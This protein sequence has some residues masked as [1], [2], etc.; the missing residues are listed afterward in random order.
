MILMIFC[1]YP[2][3]GEK[4]WKIKNYP[5]YLNLEKIKTFYGDNFLGTEFPCLVFYVN[6]HDGAKRVPEWKDFIKTH[7]PKLPVYAIGS[8]HQ[9][10]EI[11][12]GLLKESLSSEPLVYFY[13]WDG[14]V[15]QQIYETQ[16]R[17]NGEKIF[18]PGLLVF[19]LKKPNLLERKPWVIDSLSSFDQ[20]RRDIEHLLND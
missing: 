10:P 8:G 6:S 2:S 1:I 9:L 13:D 19:L 18:P 12:Q 14:S 17:F 7:F 11:L 15:I 16:D 20:V 3:F 5:A 4:N